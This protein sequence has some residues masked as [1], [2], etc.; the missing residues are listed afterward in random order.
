MIFYDCNYNFDKN[1]NI[2]EVK[3]PIDNVYNNNNNNIIYNIDNNFSLN[4]S[5]Q[6]KIPFLNNTLVK[7]KC[8]NKYLKYESTNKEITTEEMISN[9]TTIDSD[10]IFKIKYF[11]KNLKTADPSGIV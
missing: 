2:G 7:I 10:I 9:K 6:Q 8:G 3:K 11:N 5:N 1:F 4:Y